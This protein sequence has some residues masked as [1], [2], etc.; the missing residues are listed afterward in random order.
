[1]SYLGCGRCVFNAFNSCNVFQLGGISVQ[2]F[3]NSSLCNRGRLPRFIRY[4]LLLLLLLLLLPASNCGWPAGPLLDHASSSPSW[5]MDSGRGCDPVVARRVPRSQQL[6][7]NFTAYAFPI[8]EAVSR[9]LPPESQVLA[10]PRTDI[11]RR[12]RGH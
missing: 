3:A 12:R 4:L 10:E 1:M 5:A 11:L 9:A 2:L 8:T 6:G 7:T